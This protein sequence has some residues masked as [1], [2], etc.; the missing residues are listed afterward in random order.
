MPP[1]PAQ[2]NCC[3]AG[4]RR[5]DERQPPYRRTIG[6]RRCRTFGLRTERR[7]SHVYALDVPAYP[8][9]LIITDAAINIAQTLGQKR[10]ICQNAIDL[11]HVIGVTLRWSRSSRPWRRSTPRCRLRSTPRR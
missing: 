9:T 7:V 2:S 6:R 3:R 11:L 8:K 10:D 1:P 5:V 4:G